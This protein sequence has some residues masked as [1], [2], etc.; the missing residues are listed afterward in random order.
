MRLDATTKQ[1]IRFIVGR[2]HVSV[3]DDA[4]RAD[5]RRRTVP[6]AGFKAPS[7]RKLAAMEAYAVECHQKNIRL[8]NGVMLGAW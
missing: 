4:I 5:I 2:F 1:G 7:Q 6:R 3:S 8:Y